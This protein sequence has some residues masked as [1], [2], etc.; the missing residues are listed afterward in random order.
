MYKKK[1]WRE[2][3]QDAKDL[4]AIGPIRESLVSKWGPGMMLVP[5]PSEVD[6]IMKR[7]PR[8]ETIT[9]NDIRATLAQKHNAD[10]CCPVATGIFAWISAHAAEEASLEGENDTTPYWRTLKRG[11]VLNPKYPGGAEKQK[12]LL[13]AEGHAVVQ[14]GKDWVVSKSKRTNG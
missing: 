3:L 1:T 10:F 14:K 4:P 5:A 11:G 12:A 6:E 9:I 2:K 13:E 8:G 7:V